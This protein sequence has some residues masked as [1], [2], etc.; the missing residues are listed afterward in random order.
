MIDCIMENSEGKTEEI[1]REAKM[2]KADTAQ[3]RVVFVGNMWL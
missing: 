1:E 3:G 2:G